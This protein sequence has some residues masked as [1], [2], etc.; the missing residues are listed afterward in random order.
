MAVFAIMCQITISK[1]GQIYVS[2]VHYK[3]NCNLVVNTVDLILRRDIFY[4]AV[5]LKKRARLTNKLMLI[6]SSFDLLK[7][8]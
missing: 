6:F 1:L 4:V 8:Y 7:P 5:G 2:D 3:I